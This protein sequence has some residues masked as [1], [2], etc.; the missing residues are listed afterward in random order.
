MIK[1][2][3]FYSSES[4]IIICELCPNNCHLKEGQFSSCHTRKVQHGKLYTLAWNNPCALHLDP[5]E[6]KPLYHFFPGSKTL[7]ISTAGCNLQCL[8]CQNNTISQVAPKEKSSPQYAAAEI[9]KKAIDADV[10]IIAYTYTDPVA[11]YEY[12]QSIARE[13]VQKN[14][15][16]VLVTAGYINEQPLRQ[17]SGL[18]QAGNIDLKCFDNDMYHKLNSC[19][20]EPVLN[21]LQVMKEMGIWIEITNLIIP[22]W[23]DSPAMISK[24]YDW[25]VSHGFSDTPLHFSKFFPTYKLAHLSPTPVKAIETARQIA[26]DAGMKY[27]Y[28]G[29]VSGDLGANTLCPMCGKTVIARKGYSITANHLEGNLC[30]FCKTQIAG[31]FA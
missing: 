30:K 22:G 12:M 5:I 31:V 9:V 14:I 16:N 19:S 17:L 13:A 4:G 15:Q 25:L 10:Q 20:L 21:S 7:S 11:Y 26:L 27:V 24:M 29:N 6:K 23:N 1:E 2:A 28:L 8:N 3:Q 18:I